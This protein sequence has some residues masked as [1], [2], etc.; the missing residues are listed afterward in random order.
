MSRS[1]VAA[2]VAENVFVMTGTVDGPPAESRTSEARP[3]RV[4]PGTWTIAANGTRSR[5]RSAATTTS[6]NSP[7]DE[8]PTIASPG[9]SAGGYVTKSAAVT[10]TTTGSSGPACRRYSAAEARLE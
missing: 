8:M 10:G 5:W 9:P 7:E 4:E 1:S 3:V 2:S 6:L